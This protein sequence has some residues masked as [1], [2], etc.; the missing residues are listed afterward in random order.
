MARSDKLAQLYDRR[1]TDLWANLAIYAIVNAAL[2][3]AN[4]TYWPDR[5]WVHW[6]LIVW[7]AALALFYFFGVR[8]LE[9]TG[10]KK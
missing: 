4:F 3:Y 6:S 2:I 7:G 5:L 1:K 8:P 10:K 9:R